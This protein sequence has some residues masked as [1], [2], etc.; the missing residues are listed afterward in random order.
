MTGLDKIINEI[1]QEAQREAQ[2][3]LDKA[4]AKAA[5]VLAAAKE[6]AAAKTAEMNARAQKDVRDIEAARDS[7][8][9]LQRRQRTLQVKQQLLAETLQKA[10][11]SLYTLPEGEYFALLCKLAAATAQPGEGEM[12]LNEA[13]AKRMPATF[14][15]N[16]AAAL[17]AGST[18]TVS[19]NTRPIDGGF[20]LKYGDIEQ[21]NSFKA[22]FDARRD[23]FADLI[24]ETLF[25]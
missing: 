25:A 12:L 4:T 18:L 9:A 5:E 15:A 16:L 7:A 23:E 14:K 10:L 19:G 20:I 8:S 11:E 3:A 22:M 1:E 24:R 2:D 6:A 17:P 21:N 13:D